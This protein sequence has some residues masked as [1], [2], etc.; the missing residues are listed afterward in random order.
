MDFIYDVLYFC[1]L[2]FVFIDNITDCYV[3]NVWDYAGTKNVTVSGYACD[4]WT[5]HVGSVNVAHLP[6]S[7]IEDAKN[8][9]RQPTSNNWN[10]FCYS[11]NPSYSW[12]FCGINQC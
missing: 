7:T 5:N 11:T 3:N 9:C 1:Y 4:F 8:Y 2:Y 12:E 6:E 10:I